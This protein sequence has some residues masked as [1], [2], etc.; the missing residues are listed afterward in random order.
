[1]ADAVADGIGEAVVRGPQPDDPGTE[2]TGVMDAGAPMDDLTKHFLSGAPIDATIS[3]N[4]EE[5]T[6][7]KMTG[8]GQWLEVTGGKRSHH[9]IFPLAA[10]MLLCVSHR[11]CHNMS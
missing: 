8:E 7:C 6:I 10:M 3:I 4:G 11:C 9:L 1:M 5:K 2:N